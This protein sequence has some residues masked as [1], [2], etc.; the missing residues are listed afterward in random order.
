[1][2]LCNSFMITA[3]DRKAPDF[4]FCAFVNWSLPKQICRL[5]P[6]S[7][8]N[9]FKNNSKRN[10]MWSAS[11]PSFLVLHNVHLTINMNI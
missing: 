2:L 5:R 1:M 7:N 8:L 3:A 11:M 6:F 4:L 9:D 10:I